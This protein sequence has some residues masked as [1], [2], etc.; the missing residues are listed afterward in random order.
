MEPKQ[1]EIII[2]EVIEVPTSP[3]NPTESKSSKKRMKRSQDR[4]ND[5]FGNPRYNVH[6]IVANFEAMKR[7]VAMNRLKVEIFDQSKKQCYQKCVEYLLYL[8]W[9]YNST[10]K[11]SDSVIFMAVSV[12]T[13][14]FNVVNEKVFGKRLYL[15]VA[16]SFFIALKVE[17]KEWPELVKFLNYAKKFHCC[18]SCTSLVSIENEIWYQLDMQICRFTPIRILDLLFLYSRDTNY[19]IHDF[20]ELLLLISLQELPMSRFDPILNVSC[21]LYLAHRVYSIEPAWSD[22]LK[23][24]TG[25]NEEDFTEIK[26]EYFSMTKYLNHYDIRRYVDVDKNEVA[27]SLPLLNRILYNDKVI[28]HKKN[29]L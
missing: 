26:N 2:K 24:L 14:Y 11:C 25:I 7:E 5:V 1:H 18:Y 3:T 16:T 27:F 23:C 10:H 13:R 19:Q 9:E 6:Y 4:F 17:E 21:A 22:D 28:Q 29:I 8:Y 12:F 20:A 15:L